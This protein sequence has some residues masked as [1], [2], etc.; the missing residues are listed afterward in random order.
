MVMYAHARQGYKYQLTY[1]GR[2]IK[3]VAAKYRDN[4]ALHK[5]YLHC[6]PRTW[7]TNGYV[8]EV[9]EENV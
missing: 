5:Q 9:K 4:A 2:K 1:Q 6:V 7:V 3:A 8:E